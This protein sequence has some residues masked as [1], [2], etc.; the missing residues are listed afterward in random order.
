MLSSKLIKGA[1]LKVYPG[2]PH[3]MCS[4]LKNEINTELLTFFRQAQEAA[5]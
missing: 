2:A 1:T 5:A 3:G 4:T